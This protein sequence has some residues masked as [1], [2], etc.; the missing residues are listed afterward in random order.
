MNALLPV[1]VQAV[2]W[3]ALSVVMAICIC[4]LN[5]CGPRTAWRVRAM[6]VVLGGGAFAMLLDGALEWES[7]FFS[8]GVALC[9][10]AD[11]RLS[12]ACSP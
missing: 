2:Q 7:C 4:R 5:S 12:Q 6:Y 9:L 11:R 3:A 10:W 1:A 8:V